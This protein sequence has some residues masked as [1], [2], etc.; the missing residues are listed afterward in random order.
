MKLEQIIESL[1]SNESDLNKIVTLA[2]VELK[3]NM[4]L[5]AKFYEGDLLMTVLVV[6]KDFWLKN[7]TDY[8]RMISILETQFDKITS[9]D[10]SFE[11]KG[12]WY[13]KIDRFKS[14][15]AY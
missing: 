8:E 6:N 9:S 4:M 2:I 12:D 5:K 1:L 13:E 11:M 3:D 10:A 7:K 14:L 15:K